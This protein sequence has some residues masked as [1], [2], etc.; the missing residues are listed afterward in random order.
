MTGPAGSEQRN[1]PL[2]PQRDGAPDVLV[3]GVGNEAL[4]DEGVGVRVARAL[5]RRDLPKGVR[6]LEG[7]TE[8]WA[9]L[10]RLEGVRRLVLVDAMAMG[11]PPGTVV[12]VRL[13]QVRRA[14]PPERT[15][16]HGVAILDVLELA[17]ALG[18]GPREVYLVGVQPGHV[19]PGFGLSAEV[20]RA[21]P[22]AVEAAW[23]AAVRD[24]SGEGPVEAGRGRTRS[25]QVRARSRKG[26]R[27]GQA[28]AD[29]DRG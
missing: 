16:L 7:G 15:S 18:L 26:E 11:R 17:A 28:K 10:G 8:G 22:R 9:L 29:T 23:K 27:Y 13:D 19:A 4:G 6:V 20:G 2:P 24:G 25:G 5:A 21:L 12:A 3:L 1:L 14:A